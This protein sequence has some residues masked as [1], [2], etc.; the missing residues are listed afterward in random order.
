MHEE[1][2][3]FRISNILSARPQRDFDILICLYHRNIH[4]DEAVLPFKVPV[5][6]IQFK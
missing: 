1:A 5:Q 3:N 6:I 4:Q 2:F